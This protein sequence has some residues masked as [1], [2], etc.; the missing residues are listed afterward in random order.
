M[1]VTSELQPGI[2]DVTLLKLAREIAMD[3]RPL[4]GILETLEIKPT[5]W[6]YISSLPRFQGY[7]RS[8][9]EGWESATNTAERVRMKSLSFVEEAL[10]EFYARAH[11]A[12]EPLAA[13]TE[14]LKTIAKF[15]G[16]G[17]AVEGANLGERMVVTINLGADHQFTIQK[18]VTPQ[19]TDEDYE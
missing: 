5:D 12:R 1:E 11:D 14:V 16:I 18:D 10:P 13:K 2:S 6:E 17:G 3:I 4:E 19:V 15:A 8:A 7:L 9:V